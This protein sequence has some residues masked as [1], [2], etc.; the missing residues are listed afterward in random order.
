MARTTSYMAICFLLLFVASGLGQDGFVVE[1]VGGP[2]TGPPVLDAPFSAEAI[3]TVKARHRNGA[4]IDQRTTMRLFRDRAG[5]V[6]VEHLMEGLAP[7]RTSNERAIR[8]IVDPEPGD[9]WVYALDLVTKTARRLP[10]EMVAMTAG[11]GQ[12]FAVPTGGVRF[13]DFRRA[14][15]GHIWGLP[16]IEA[17]TESLG[18]RQIEGIATI[19]RRGT[20]NVGS[21]RLVDERWESPELRLTMRARSSDSRTGVVEYELKSIDRR[22][23]IPG[24]FELPPEFTLSSEATA[25]DGRLTLSR[26]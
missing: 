4:P 10:R 17:A 26:P 9:G 21:I 25:E 19:G 24:L 5:R 23:P 8:T 13:L 1:P 7:P 2:L 16:G 18:P 12:G 6:R 14:L 3:T 22:E 15:D 11:G 20:I